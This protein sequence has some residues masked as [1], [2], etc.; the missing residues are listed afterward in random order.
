MQF[1]E[2]EVIVEFGPGGGVITRGILSRMR[3]DATLIAIE[4][5]ARFAKALE[6]TIEDPR[7]RVFNDSAENVLDI[8]ARCNKSSARHVISGIPFSMFPNELKDRILAATKQALSAQGT[9]LVY[10]FFSNPFGHGD[11]IRKKLDEHMD[12]KAEEAEFLNIPPLRIF[13]A[14]RKFSP[15]TANG[16]L[17]TGT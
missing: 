13:T 1:S 2:A 12:I 7:L 17:R 3:Q 9:F 8:L 4:Q 10:Q 11:D 15:A 5:N 16:P 6:E 14:A